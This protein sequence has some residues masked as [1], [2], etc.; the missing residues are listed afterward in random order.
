M[1]ITFQVADSLTA[2]SPSQASFTI[3]FP[4]PPVVKPIPTQSVLDVAGEQFSLD[5]GDYASDPNLPPLP[6]TYSLAGNP[7]AGMN[8]DPDSGMLT[9]VVPAGQPTGITAITVNIS[10]DQSPPDTTS[11]VVTLDLLLPPV[12]QPIPTQDGLDINGDPFILN[13]GD[14]ASDPNG[15]SSP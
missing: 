13:V 15:P 2:A 6:L 12:V 8:I 10:D 14:Y 4:L 11:A 7:P 3:D 5:V 9:W 1:T